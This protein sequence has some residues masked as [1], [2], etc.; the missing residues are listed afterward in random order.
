MAG[1]AP[2]GP[3]PSSGAEQSIP[4][5]H[6]PRN[7]R[8]PISSAAGHNRTQSRQGDEI[9]GLH[10]EGPATNLE[11]FAIAGVDVN[12]L[13]TVGGR[14]RPG[15][16]HA[17]HDDA[18]AAVAR[19]HLCPRPPARGTTAPARFLRARPSTG[20]KSRNHESGALIQGLKTGR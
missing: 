17:R 12:Q 18:R 20:V 6:S 3:M 10:I 16:E 15:G 4:L 5:D 8:R 19:P 2:S 1:T 11:R 13:D 9:A 7:F 14:V